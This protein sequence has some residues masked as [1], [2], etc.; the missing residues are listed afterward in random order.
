MSRPDWLQ[1]SN[2]RQFWI[3]SSNDPDVMIDLMDYDTFGTDPS[4]LDAKTKN[5]SSYADQD[6]IISEYSLEYSEISFT[7]LTGYQS[8]KPYAVF[9]KNLIKQLNKKGLVLHYQ[10]GE[11]EDKKTFIRD[12]TFIS[13]TKSEL[14]EYGVLGVVLT[15]KPLTPWYNW[16][17]IYSTETG[18]SWKPGEK[19]TLKA[20]CRSKGISE[21]IVESFIPFD[22]FDCIHF[23]PDVTVPI[24][25]YWKT[26][27][28]VNEVGLSMYDAAMNLVSN[29]KFT[30][31]LSK[32]VPYFLFSS[33]FR[34][35]YAVTSS[36]GQN[37]VIN[38]MPTMSTDSS[39]FM[40]AKIN[41]RLYLYLGPGSLTIG[42]E[43]L[44]Q[45]REEAVI[46]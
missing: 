13:I 34:E 21:G 26:A 9:R 45:V 18:A 20:I 3:T 8:E 30:A 10:C 5:A 27:T 39:G 33:D 29:A 19:D 16:K 46:V 44:V 12:V 40:R 23:I 24:K 38:V 2:V 25:L 6:V 1:T 42:N 17:T 11:D 36:D 37:G 43:A 4:G 32:S 15:L 35:P 28:S 14:N 22:T 31:A 7:V 41:E